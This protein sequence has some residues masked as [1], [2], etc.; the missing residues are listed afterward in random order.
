MRID[1]VQEL[2]L[3]PPGSTQP[4]LGPYETEYDVRRGYD[5]HAPV[6]AP[7]LCAAREP[8]WIGRRRER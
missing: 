6:V 3:D 5:E 1:P 7:A 4:R 8:V 2:L